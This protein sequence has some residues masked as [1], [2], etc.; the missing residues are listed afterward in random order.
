MPVSA[1]L[2]IIRAASEA[3]ERLQ[4]MN[5]D[6]VLLDT[7]LP[8]ATGLQALR[9]TARGRR[10]TPYCFDRIRRLQRDWSRCVK[11]RGTI[12]KTPRQRRRTVARRVV[13][14]GTQYLSPRPGAR[15]AITRTCSITCPSLFLRIT[16]A[17]S[18][19]P[20]R[21][22]KLLAATASARQVNFLDLLFEPGG[23][24]TSPDLISR[25]RMVGL[26]NHH[27]RLQG[28]TLHVIVNTAPLYDVADFRRLGRLHHRYPMLKQTL[29]RD[30]LGTTCDGA[31]ARGHWPAGAVSRT[32][33]YA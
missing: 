2:D 29:R 19:P 31:E 18:R 33:Q 5:Y 15:D 9:A 26:E 10:L 21:Q 17:S 24:R 11:A 8:D 22:R 3:A 32:N 6:L 28:P 23:A 4:T 20:T 16:M 1:G 12:S 30:R 25:Q 13:L 27:P 7:G 14:G